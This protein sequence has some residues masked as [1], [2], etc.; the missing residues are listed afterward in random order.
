MNYDKYMNEFKNLLLNDDVSDDFKQILCGLIHAVNKNP[1]KSIDMGYIIRNTL[2]SYNINST[3]NEKKKNNKIEFKEVDWSSFIYG[4]SY[5]LSYFGSYLPTEIK[6]YDF[7]HHFGKKFHQIYKGMDGKIHLKYQPKCLLKSFSAASRGAE[8]EHYVELV[9]EPD[10]LRKLNLTEEDNLI[11]TNKKNLL[12]ELINEN[13]LHYESR[14]SN[15]N[16]ILIP[17]GDEQQID[18]FDVEFIKILIEFITSNKEKSSKI[19]LNIL[20]NGEELNVSDVIYMYNTFAKAGYENIA[21]NSFEMETY[22][23]EYTHPTPIAVKTKKCKRINWVME[24]SWIKQIDDID[25]LNAIMIN[26]SK[27]FV[28]SK[29]SL[30]LDINKKFSSSKNID[31]FI[32]FLEE[33]GIYNYTNRLN[34]I[35]QKVRA[36]KKF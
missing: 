17:L 25:Y 22:D 20:D 30:N 3:A 2:N 10:D 27:L 34:A 32:I 7:L 4:K 26:S 19:L 21:L 13:K 28:D 18:E 11:L 23:Y 29:F 35:K 9:L 36:R 31:E 15:M 6:N 5:N 24:E 14:I 16:K 33:R 1:D 12:D 8:K